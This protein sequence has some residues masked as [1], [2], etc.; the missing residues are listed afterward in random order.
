M[1]AGALRTVSRSCL[2]ITVMPD[3]QRADD[4]VDMG[5]VFDAVVDLEHQLRRIAQLQHG[6]QLP[7]EPAGGRPQSAAKLLLALHPHDGEPDLAVAQIPRG[8]H[9]GDA[10]HPLL[11]P[12]ILDIPQLCREHTL[13]VVVDSCDLVG[14]H[15][16]ISILNRGES[17]SHL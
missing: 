15:F 9:A 7:P 5:A 11:D 10:D 13:D 3:I 14:C 12:G 2:F 8:L 4:L 17:F 1:S 16:Q 6:A